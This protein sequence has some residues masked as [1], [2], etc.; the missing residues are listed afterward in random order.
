[1]GYVSYNSKP[2]CIYDSF[3]GFFL[4]IFLANGLGRNTNKG[5]DK[6]SNEELGLKHGPKRTK[7]RFLSENLETVIIQYVLYQALL[8]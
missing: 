3:Y 6:L 7:G 4:K 1:M 5:C 2:G 8:F